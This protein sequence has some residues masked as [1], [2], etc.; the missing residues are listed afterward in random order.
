[1]N[2]NVEKLVP[3]SKIKYKN[4]WYQ[5]FID[6]SKKRYFLKINNN[7]YEYVSIRELIELKKIYEE[8][9]T[10]IYCEKNNIKYVAFLGLELITIS[11]MTLKLENYKLDQNGYSDVSIEISNEQ[12]DTFKQVTREE[13]LNY[14]EVSND[15]DYILDNNPNIGE[16][17]I[18]YI[19]EFIEKYSNEDLTLFYY[20]M[21]NVTI[22]CLSE[23]EIKEK[24]NNPS[25]TAYFDFVN[26]KIVFNQDMILE[27]NKDTI[28][29][30]FRHACKCA[31]ITEDEQ[32]IYISFTMVTE[33]NIEIGKSILEG[34]NAKYTSFTYTTQ[35]NYIEMLIMILGEE[36]LKEFEENGDLESLI[37]SLEKIDGTKE[38]AIKLIMLMDDELNSINNNIIYSKEN[39]IEIRTRLMNYFLKN[40]KLK[41]DNSTEFDY[42]IRYSNYV[43][44]CDEFEE[45][46]KRQIICI[47]QG[48]DKDNNERIEIEKETS[49]RMEELFN[50]RKINNLDKYLNKYNLTIDEINDF[51]SWI[52]VKTEATE[53]KIKIENEN[54]KIEYQD[55]ITYTSQDGELKTLY[56]YQIYIKKSYIIDNEEEILKYISPEEYINVLNNLDNKRR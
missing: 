52:L 9:F 5:I 21:S 2:L 17:Y 48:N 10:G 49:S 45:L 8:E 23:E 51:N 15:I 16:E 22:E 25:A 50:E 12:N 26:H 4:N 47:E 32:T 40:E 6:E 29:H 38:D 14:I 27:E 28:F 33:D 44:N 55:P 20:N 30:E 31:S 19:K 36:K 35:K 13:F 42:M 18:P 1:M 3:L 39:K 46:I 24:L 34:M 37:N 54:I 56:M 53:E 41:L 11:L 7:Q 43:E